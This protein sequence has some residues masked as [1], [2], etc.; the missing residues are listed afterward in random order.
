M[1][2]GRVVSVTLSI[3][4]I[5]AVIGG[6][7]G[8]VLLGASRPLS[9]DDAK[10]AGILAVGGAVGAAMGAVLAPI[11]AWV[12]LRRVALGKALLQTTIGTTIGAAIGLVFD[13]IALPSL[14]SV[15]MGIAA[16]LVGFLAAALRLRFTTRT[17]RRTAGMESQGRDT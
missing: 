10:T 4:V 12:F 17:P 5:G 13:R 7:V 8:A 2:P 1:R 15:P 9:F 6:V 11:T 16:A 14:R 3:A